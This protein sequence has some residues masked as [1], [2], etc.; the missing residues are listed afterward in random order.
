MKEFI[1]QFMKNVCLTLRRMKP[2]ALPSVFFSIL[3]REL[4]VGWAMGKVCSNHG[5][6]KLFC[7]QGHSSTG[8]PRGAGRHWHLME[9]LP[10]ANPTRCTKTWEP[11]SLNQSAPPFPPWYS[12]PIPW[13]HRRDEAARVYPGLDRQHVTCI[14]AGT[15]HE[16][17]NQQFSR[18]PLMAVKSVLYKTRMWRLRS[19]TCWRLPRSEWHL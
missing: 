13:G 19:P 7:T 16:Q 1:C 9:F 12:F 17:R 2:N 15:G 5:S 14:L 3:S 11:R 8:A 18:R 6:D 4:R 10:A